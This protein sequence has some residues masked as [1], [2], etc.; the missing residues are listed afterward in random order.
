MNKTTCFVKEF[1]S[2]QQMTKIGK[3]K[4]VYKTPEY[5]DYEW[6]L[7]PGV[8]KLKKITNPDVPILLKLTF[9]VKGGV[10]L[11]TW[12]LIMKT[13]GNTAKICYS[14]EEA[15]KHKKNHH[16]IS[17]SGMKILYGVTGDIDNL[18][19]PIQDFIELMGKVPNDRQI[20]KADTNFTYN[21]KN[22]FV[23]IELVE[24]VPYMDINNRLRFKEKEDL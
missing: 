12:R 5:I 1:G 3:W 24:L 2:Y 21:N 4:N 17:Y 23:D 13:T 7:K 11:P 18:T 22:N 15:L 6:Q 16:N 9:N 20:R 10:E 8:M 14:E 19:K